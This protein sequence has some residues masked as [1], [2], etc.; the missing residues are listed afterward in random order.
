MVSR[1]PA[2]RSARFADDTD[3]GPFAPWAR[4]LVLLARDSRDAAAAALRQIPDPPR[5]LLF[6]AMWCL[7]GHAAI[8]LNDRPTI[9]RARTELAPAANELAGAGG[10]RPA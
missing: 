5:D 1:F 2:A 7:S 6:E 8:A 9:E 10:G 4:P 3:W